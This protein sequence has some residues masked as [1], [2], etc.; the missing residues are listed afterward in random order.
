L[1]DD[2][3]TDNLVDIDMENLDN[4]RSQFFSEEVDSKE[5][6]KEVEE[7][8]PEEDALATDEDESEDEDSDESEEDSEDE[9]EEDDNQPRAKHKKRQSFQQRLNEV[10]ADKKAAEREVEV[11]RR[12]LD[13][14][15]SR[16]EVKQEPQVAVKAEAPKAPTPD[17]VNDKGEPL[18]P[19]GEIDPN[20]IANLTRF[21]VMQEMQAAE[22]KRQE[23]T[24]ARQVQE[25]QKLIQQHWAENLEAA[26][27]EL[28]DI[29]EKISSM[30]QVFQGIEPSYGE[31]LAGTIM[32][33][34]HGPEIMYYLS[35]NIG[36]AQK[37]VASGPAAATLAIGRLEASL[38]KPQTEERKSNK[39]VSETPPPPEVRTRGSGGRFSVRPDTRDLAAFS[40]VF[41]SDD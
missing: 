8:S 22:Q 19:L 30:V 24:Q 10:Y 39:R 38:T 16:T 6:V 21:T 35:Q 25:Q 28:P 3:S 12:E 36:E 41:F 14:A 37:I 31:Y 26:E 13:L 9:D 40:K 7:D 27:E 34:D 4:F 5:E 18:Y 23:E 32:S 2:N 29:R 20:F 11:L 17:D 33:C 1:T 15:R